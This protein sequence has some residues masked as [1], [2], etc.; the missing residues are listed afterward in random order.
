VSDPDDVAGARPWPPAFSALFVDQTRALLDVQPVLAIIGPV[1]GNR[2][3]LAAEVARMPAGPSNNRH[4][5]RHGD[6]DRPFFAITQLFRELQLPDPV[7]GETI[8]SSVVESL[9]D[10]DEPPRI[11]LA[12]A[13][14]CDPPSLGLLVQVAEAGAIRLIATLAPDAVPAHEDLVAA[15]GLVEIPPLDSAMI[16]ELLRVRFGAAPHPE[17]TALLL[18]RSLGSYAVVQELV[19]TAFASG[20]IVIV[21]GVL[22]LN[23]IRQAAGPERLSNRLVPPVN[24]PGRDAAVADLVHLTALLDGLDLEEARA[25]VG[26]EIVDLATRPGGLRVEDDSVVFTLRSEAQLVQ[27]SLPQDRRI[28]LFDRFAAAF[29]RTLA[30][31]AT[32]VPAAD[33]WRAAG[34]LL[35]VELAGRAG[36]E[37]NLL[38]HY[39]RAL[40]Y[41]DAAS[42]EQHTAVAPAERAFALGELGD[43]TS[44]LEMLK[45]LDPTRLAEDELY[46][47]L[48][49]V[50][51]LDQDGD[52]EELAG[53]AVSS[54][55]PATRRRREAV[56]T[57]E[58]MIHEAIGAGGEKL[59]VR[60][61]ALA[62]SG[63][64][65]PGNRAI[66]FA[67]LA[68][69]LH[70]SARPA[71]AT[72]AAGFALDSL[73]DD[74]TSVSA[75]HL[76]AAHE[77][78][79]V[80][81][82]SA[83]DLP[84]ADRALAVYSSGSLTSPGSGRMSGALQTY[85]AMAH[86]D[87]SGALANAHLSLSELRRHD[88]HQ[89]RGWVEAMTAQ[90]L[91]HLGRGDE[92]RD[93]LDAASRHAS[94]HP[95][96]DLVR[97]TYVGLTYDALA[98]PEEA[99][100]ILGAVVEEA[101]S[102]G[103]RLAQIEAAGASVLVGGPPQLDL[104]VEAVDD[105]VDPSGTPEVW[106]AYARA[107]RRYDIPAIVDLALRLD[108]LDARLF[109]A[110]VAQS[111]LDMARR[112]TDLTPQTRDRLTRIADLSAA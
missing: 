111:V 21:E 56:R 76:A 13:E 41:T 36:R 72:E 101:R 92:A 52:G 73:L 94:R 69:V 10:A 107:A 103:L 78:H 4:V 48:R 3:H 40:V 14:L 81:L 106:Q 5:A 70:H 100:E 66:A 87:M 43:D 45:E 96:T 50:R 53:Q 89:I 2:N 84:Q 75:F 35:P 59:A 57:L 39:R 104:L 91:V 28:E 31:P 64:L 58:A 47:Y 6:R 34:R 67:A 51:R 25:A 49:A 32:A 18:E 88:P 29:P 93:A 77:L 26:A 86:G 38:G 99:L 71:Q 9:R 65:S 12:N 44:L 33:W 15:S 61:R 97:R 108:A 90:S 27:R 8:A 60:L 110:G 16:A 17:V 83:L 79:V 11:V 30:R 7:S 23:P 82:V 42:N 74:A 24:G 63:L 46:P 1:G 105:L 112:A 102:R 95:Q 37:A 62:F 22:A 55:D 85:V 54:D 68:I 109:A 80:S 98:E 19:D 20:A